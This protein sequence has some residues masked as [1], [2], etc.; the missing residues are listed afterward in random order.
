MPLENKTTTLPITSGLSESFEIPVYD[1]KEAG[2]DKIIVSKSELLNL[3]IKQK[4][5]MHQEY[6]E[7]GEDRGYA[8][9][10]FQDFID[11]YDFDSSKFKESIGNNYIGKPFYPNENVLAGQAFEAGRSCNPYLLRK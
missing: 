8:F 1:Y 10:D 6:C 9:L 3:L 11:N 4:R 5:D 7:I 2:D